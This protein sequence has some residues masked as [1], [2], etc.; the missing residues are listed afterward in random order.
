MRAG[1]MS[2]APDPALPPIEPERPA[3]GP[4]VER[5]VLEAFGPGRYAKTAER[6]REGAAPVTDLSFVAWEGG[7]AVG[8]VR[9]WPLQIGDRAGLL[10]GPFAVDPRFRSRGLGA[11]LIARAC[12][13]AAAAGWELV[14]L[15]GDEPYYRPL[16][17]AA[18]P[19]AR[20]VLPG[21]VDRR[22]VLVRALK[23]GADQGLE[24]P[25]LAA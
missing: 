14:L 24:G 5:L 8:C 19:A 18:A 20:L 11:A 13:A 4:A 23:E 7:Q 25:V 9:L 21:P 15:V 12:S 6:L 3:D 10:L 22:R 16:G 1:S 2:L 17:F